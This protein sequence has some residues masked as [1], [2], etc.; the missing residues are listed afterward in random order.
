MPHETKT[1]EAAT[2]PESAGSATASSSESVGA[3]GTRG[4]APLSKEDILKIAEDPY[5]KYLVDK[6]ARSQTW[7]F[8]AA[9]GSVIAAILLYAG[10][11]FKSAK[12]EI[13]KNVI[14]SQQATE[15][16][17]KNSQE[18]QAMADK[19]QGQIEAVNALLSRSQSYGQE[20][21]QMAIIQAAQEHIRT[22]TDLQRVFFD[23]QNKLL[24]GASAE[25]EQ[26]NRNVEQINKI[27]KGLDKAE[28]SKKLDEVNKE[29]K[30]I[31]AA[32]TNVKNM[33]DTV[34]EKVKEVNSQVQSLK[35]LQDVNFELVKARSAESVTLR[36]HDSIELKLP[37]LEHLCADPNTQSDLHVKFTVEGLGT[38]FNL[39]WRVRRDD[40]SEVSEG[41]QLIKSQ[42]TH[43]SL[44]ENTFSLK[45]TPYEVVVE[46][47]NYGIFAHDFVVLKVRPQRKAVPCKQETSAKAAP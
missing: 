25:T 30:E 4:P 6:T 8:L 13:D 15:S 46:F 18:S 26:A 35:T 39:H 3:D 12:S 22:S 21:E 31:N 2:I 41:A 43:T 5:F 10:L 7:A 16:V 37:D 29:I 17:K 44:D 11:E 9:V 33:S 19:A 14:M 40:D 23:S 34:A 20:S 42:K 1:D 24:A 45:N 47:A 36:A 27:L 28:I 38:S 32:K